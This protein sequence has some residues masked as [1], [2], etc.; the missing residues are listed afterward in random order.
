MVVVVMVIQ[1]PTH[2]RLFVAPWTA[3][4]QAPLFFTISRSLLKLMSFELVMPDSK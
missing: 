2:V 3:A 1:W 4:H